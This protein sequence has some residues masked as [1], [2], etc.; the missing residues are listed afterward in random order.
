MLTRLKKVVRPF[1]GHL[2]RPEAVRSV[3]PPSLGIVLDQQRAIYFPIP[4]VAC[5]SLKKICADLLGLEVPILPGEVPDV[6][7]MKSFPTVG[8]DQV[9]CYEG[10]FKFAFVRNPWYRLVSNY[11]DK[12]KKDPSISNEWTCRGVFRPYVRYNRFY[13]GMPFDA[14]VRGICQIPDHDA[15]A[16]FR[17]QFTFVHNQRGERIVD[18]VGK[19]ENAATDFPLVLQR[20]GVT[21]LNVPRLH[22]SSHDDYKGYYTDELIQL[23]RERFLRDVETFGYD[24]A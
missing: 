22:R 2:P 7:G 20:L 14:F 19:L 16:H 5:S 17:S 21:G 9:G 1:L 23:V 3:E 15:N 11:S 8:K 13:A 10:Y 24:F 12:I 4:K 18:F 6:H